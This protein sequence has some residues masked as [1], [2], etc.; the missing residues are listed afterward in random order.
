MNCALSTNWDLSLTPDQMID[1]ALALGFDSLELGFGT[2]AEMIKAYQRRLS[3][4]PVTSL[5]AFCPV[6]IG[7]PMAHPEVYT[8]ASYRALMRNL[9]RMHLAHT[10][11]TAASLGATAVVLHAGRISLARF[12]DANFS[13]RT[14]CAALEAAQKDVMNRRF[15]SLTRTAL[16]MRRR[17]GK[18]MVD[19]FSRELEALIPLLQETGVVLGLENLPYLE[20]FPNEDELDALL[21]RFAGAPI[22]GWFDTGHDRVR[23][24]FGWVKGTVEDALAHPEKFIGTHLNDVKDFTDD[25]LAPYEANVDFDG[26]MPFFRQVSHVVFEPHQHVTAERLGAALKHFRLSYSQSAP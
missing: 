4:M 9:A 10:I 12:F 25:H 13:S 14:L 15:Q 7:A 17:R 20:A 19:I 21:T 6:P 3:E 1:Q 26:L 11:T 16:K 8:L 18:R 24:S 23:T 5:H 22:R 2:R